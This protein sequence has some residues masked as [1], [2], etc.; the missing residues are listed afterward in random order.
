M[1]DISRSDDHAG[2]ALIDAATGLL[3][4]RKPDVPTDFIRKLFGLVPQ[5][6]C[7][8][9]GRLH[10]KLRMTREKAADLLGIFR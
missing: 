2:A 6:A 4:K 8:L 5:H 9:F 10:R 7:G 1:N 3:A